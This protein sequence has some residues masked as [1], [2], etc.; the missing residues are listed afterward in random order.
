MA[1]KTHV[2]V[3]GAGALAMGRDEHGRT[4][5]TATCSSCAARRSIAFKSYNVP[6]SAVTKK[7]HQSG[8]SF[9]KRDTV[10]LCPACQPIAKK[11][12]MPSLDAHKAQ[13]TMFT[14]LEEHFDPA[15][16]KFD[17]GWS[18][19]K[20][21]KKTK[22]AESHVVEVRESAFGKLQNPELLE[23]RQKIDALRTTLAKETAAIEEM[24]KETRAKGAREIRLF[25]ERLTK[26]MERAP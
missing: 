7:F 12:P 9:A 19:A 10:A 22:L 1:T 21:A 4:C 20:I 17:V 18:D 3:D 16:G 26:A 25:N 24:L 8:W 15:T 5:V 13:R 6:R 23:L 14:L 2:V 11:Q